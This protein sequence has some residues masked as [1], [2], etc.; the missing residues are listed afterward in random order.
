MQSLNELSDYLRANP[1]ECGKALAIIGEN[2][3]VYRSNCEKRSSVLADNAICMLSSLID[4]DK[5]EKWKC[6]KSNSASVIL[7]DAVLHECRAMNSIGHSNSTL[8][9]I[10]TFNKLCDKSGERNSEDYLVF[11]RATKG[12]KAVEIVKY[13]WNN[14]E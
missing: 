3:A 8:T 12:D 4:F 7:L 1:S 5:V 13:V 11:V 14:Y 2:L 9:L 6:T 10:K